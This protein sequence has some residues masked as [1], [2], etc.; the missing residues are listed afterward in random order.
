MA[1][2]QS[3][4][5][6]TATPPTHNE[7]ALPAPVLLPAST[8]NEAVADEVD[9]RATFSNHPA[10][11]SATDLLAAFNKSPNRSSAKKTHQKG[12]HDI[13]PLLRKNR[14]PLLEPSEVAAASHT[15]AWEVRA[16]DLFP[17]HSMPNPG[18]AGAGGH[19]SPSPTSPSISLSSSNSSMPIDEERSSAGRRDATQQH[20]T[21]YT[22]KEGRSLPGSSPKSASRHSV[23]TPTAA[24]RRSPGDRH[25]SSR[26][27]SS[28]ILQGERSDADED[29]KQSARKES[30][31]K[32]K[33]HSGSRD[34]K[35]GSEDKE[36]KPSDLQT[37][38]KNRSTP[39]YASGLLRKQQSEDGTLL[40]AKSRTSSGPSHLAFQTSKSCS[41]VSARVDEGSCSETMAQTGECSANV[42]SAAESPCSE[43]EAEAERT[44]DERRRKKFGSFLFRTRSPSSR[45]HKHG[46]KRRNSEGYL[47]PRQLSLSSPRKRA[48]SIA[49]TFC[50]TS[51]DE[52]PRPESPD[53]VKSVVDFAPVGQPLCAASG[54][55]A[56]R[57][58]KHVEEEG[59][60]SESGARPAAAGASESGDVLASLFPESSAARQWLRRGRRE[61]I[62]AAAD[63]LVASV[64]SGCEASDD[65]AVHRE[66]DAATAAPRAR[67]GSVISTMEASVDFPPQYRRRRRGSVAPE[68]L[69]GTKRSGVGGDLLAPSAAAEVVRENFLKGRV[70]SLAKECERLEVSIRHLQANC[71]RLNQQEKELLHSWLNGQR[72]KRYKPQ[73]GA[74][75]IPTRGNTKPVFT[76]KPVI[77]H[78]RKLADSKGSGCS[79]S[80]VSVDGWQCVAKTLDLEFATKTQ[81]NAFTNEVMI[82]QQLPYHKNIVRYLFHQESKNTLTLFMSHYRCTLRDLLNQYRKKF[83]DAEESEKRSHLLPAKHVCNAMLDLVAALQF[84]QSLNLVHLDVKSEN[85]FVTMN[86]DNSTLGVL[87][88][89]DFDTT[90]NLLNGNITYA[91][92]TPGWMAPEVSSIRD[93]DAQPI[94][95]GFYSDVFSF[96][97]LL[98][99]MLTL[100]EPFEGV[101]VMDIPDLVEAGQAP[102]IPPE[103]I[104]NRVEFPEY[105]VL[106]DIHERCTTLDPADRIDLGTVKAELLD[107]LETC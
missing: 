16:V 35:E 37:R 55:R 38:L 40:R 58:H 84:L 76:D 91:C 74:L 49:V 53:G 72:G 4:P 83:N 2:S 6:C 99:E 88:L 70:D 57:Q 69:F 42:S 79:I 56:A 102:R 107:L 87:S 12:S 47:K 30:K 103:V 18:G 13:P 59:S 61:S 46:K 67:R 20:V 81:L 25:S 9:R 65:L 97:M 71:D 63:S 101:K 54:S 77:V 28:K 10:R 31:K 96:G 68:M 48:G 90:H 23:T 34:R 86:D 92:G 21:I 1:T 66:R 89:G 105:A 78:L 17:S 64:D 44:G 52:G 94:Q 5:P 85:V 32:K 60:C 93:V 82:L 62:A 24:Q 106:L 22:P 19:D 8:S 15:S 29:E 14:V 80:L 36:G 26:R 11:D 100:Q 51:E 41:Q 98:F 95:V 39:R 33:K 7:A 45:Q 43:E 73:K 3:S 27:H 50:G 75:H 104:A